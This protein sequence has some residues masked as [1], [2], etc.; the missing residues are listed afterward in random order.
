[1]IRALFI[2]FSA[3]NPQMQYPWKNTAF[4][5]GFIIEIGFSGWTGKWAA[6]MWN[7]IN[8][9][10]SLQWEENKWLSIDGKYS[11]EKGQWLSFPLV[12]DQAQKL[13]GG[14]SFILYINNREVA[15]TTTP[16]PQDIP[17]QKYLAI[18]MSGAEHFLQ[19]AY[20]ANM[21]HNACGIFDEF[22]IW[23]DAK[24]PY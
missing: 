21:Y 16:I 20:P 14:K 5:K 4:N 19:S 1:M 24:I 2:I 17:L 12:W 8:F 7:P 22:Y 18:R 9:G 6:H 13:P 15:S 3:D 11:F 23:S 10:Q